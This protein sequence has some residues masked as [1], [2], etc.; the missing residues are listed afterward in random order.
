LGRSSERAAN[1][2]FD[3]L[4]AIVNVARGKTQESESRVD[5]QVLPAV[6]FDQAVPVI[7][8]VVLDN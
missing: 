2:R 1:L 7:P 5:Q 4:W 3:D 8:A 6:V